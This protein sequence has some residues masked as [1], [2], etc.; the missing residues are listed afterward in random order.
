MSDPTLIIGAVLAPIVLL[1]V[2]S[3]ILLQCH[4]RGSM[5]IRKAARLFIVL[6]GVAVLL[7][8]IVLFA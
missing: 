4:R 8:G 7:S 2:G 1:S 5:S 6:G 3:A